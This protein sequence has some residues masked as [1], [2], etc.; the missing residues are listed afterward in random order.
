MKSIG[1]LTQISKFIEFWLGYCG[2]IGNNNIT[3]FCRNLLLKKQCKAK[4]NSNPENIKS[5]KS[6]KKTNCFKKSKK[7]YWP[8]KKWSQYFKLSRY[9]YF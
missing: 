8:V 3:Q 7:E 5:K 1:E 4:S 2:Y 9:I 6:S